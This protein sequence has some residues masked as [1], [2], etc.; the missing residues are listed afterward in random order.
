M[1]SMI[2]ALR[3]AT[4]AVTPTQAP[5]DLLA[6]ICA[7]LLQDRTT[8]S[9]LRQEFERLCEERHQ[10]FHVKPNISGQYNDTPKFVSDWKTCN[11]PVCK[12]AVELIEN[13]AKPDIMINAFM[14]Q[15]VKDKIVMFEG[16]PAG[17]HIFLADKDVIKQP[18]LIVLG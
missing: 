16:T 1:G 18:K 5:Y 10:H 8:D 7:I 3:K 14:P 12:H 6:T 17:I 2:N 15:A 13:A 11:N 9:D 4:A